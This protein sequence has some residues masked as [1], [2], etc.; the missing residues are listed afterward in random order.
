M[1][2]SVELKIKRYERESIDVLINRKDKRDDEWVLSYI[3]TR[4][5]ERGGS[6]ESALF[7]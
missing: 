5:G 3:H 2:S 6:Q 1:H 7:N 4:E